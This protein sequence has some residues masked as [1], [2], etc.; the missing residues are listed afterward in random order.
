[1]KIVSFSATAFTLVGSG[2]AHR[3]ANNEY[4]FSDSVILHVSSPCISGEVSDL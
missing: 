1:M 2:F 4:M 3:D